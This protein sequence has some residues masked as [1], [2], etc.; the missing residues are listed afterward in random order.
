MELNELFEIK[1]EYDRK[2][3]Q[4]VQKLLK[5]KKIC[6]IIGGL[7]SSGKTSLA[8]YFVENDFFYIN[9]DKIKREEPHTYLVKIDDLIKEHD[10]V[11]IEGRF[12]YNKTREHFFKY[13]PVFV[14]INCPLKVILQRNEQIEATERHFPDFQLRTLYK[15]VELPI[16]RNFQSYIINVYEPEAEY[17]PNYLVPKVDV[18]Y[19][20]ISAKIRDVIRIQK[21]NIMEDYRSLYKVDY[22]RYKDARQQLE[23]IYRIKRLEEMDDW[24]K[25]H[26]KWQYILPIFNNTI[27]YNQNNINH[28]STLHEH[29][30][31]AA[32]YSHEYDS[33]LLTFLALLFHDIGKPQ[34]LIDYGIVKD[35]TDVFNKGEKVEIKLGDNGLISA[36]SIRE[37]ELRQEL[38]TPNLIEKQPNSHYYNHPNVGAILLYQQLSLIGFNKQELDKIYRLV[39]NHMII[40]ATYKMNKQTIDK[41]RKRNKDILNE[42]YIVHKCDAK[43]TGVPLEVSYLDE[44][45]Q[46]ILNK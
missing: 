24:L 36:S 27:D 12:I 11:V 34:T 3:L 26:V 2:T 32:F 1:S 18:K 10:K 23:Y 37:K 13:N 8:K 46:S 5:R 31:R 14:F 30:Y 44:N 42:L 41:F 35:D 45:W 40:S 17:K 15:Y 22:F 38:L 9:K 33:D 25:R 43:A 6:L 7:P 28:K 19:D 20:S 21:H 4:S 16:Y 29:M 39:Y